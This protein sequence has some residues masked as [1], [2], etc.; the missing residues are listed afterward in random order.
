MTNVKLVEEWPYVSVEGI[1]V[2]RR[3]IVVVLDKRLGG[4]NKEKDVL[5]RQNVSTRFMMV[6]NAQTLRCRRVLPTSI[7][8]GRSP[9]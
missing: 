1:C 5:L 6:Q 7:S 8:R 9:F 4:L 3:R 2:D